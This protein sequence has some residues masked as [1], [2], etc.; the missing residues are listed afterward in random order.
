[1]SSHARL[2]RIW[3]VRM[4]DCMEVCM[5]VNM[6]ACIYYSSIPLLRIGVSCCP[7]VQV[8]VSPIKCD[9]G[10]CATCHMAYY[11]CPVPVPSQPV[12]KKTAKETDVK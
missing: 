1:M 7:V 8:S 12:L 11:W 2:S 3:Y 6:Y 10:Y 5:D 9:L 4:Y